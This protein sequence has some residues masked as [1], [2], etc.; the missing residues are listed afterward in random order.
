MESIFKFFKELEEI[1]E[2]TKWAQF[3]QDTPEENSS[4]DEIDPLQA[5]KMLRTDERQSG[6]HDSIEV[7]THNLHELDIFIKYLLTDIFEDTKHDHATHLIE[8]NKTVRNNSTVHATHQ[9]LHR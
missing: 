9:S 5:A 3:Y 8:H 7:Q 1:D 6:Y 2:A 4:E